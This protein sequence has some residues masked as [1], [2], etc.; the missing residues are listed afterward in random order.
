MN[1]CTCTM[2]ATMRNTKLVRVRHGKGAK[3]ISRLIKS[4]SVAAPYGTLVL[5]EMG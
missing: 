4:N 1:V 5:R 3:T 2:K